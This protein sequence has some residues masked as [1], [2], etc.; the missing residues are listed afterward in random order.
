MPASKDK[1]T[2]EP[3][4]AAWRSLINVHFRVVAQIERDLAAANLISLSWY[5]VLFALV[6]APGRRL[7]LNELARKAV[8]SRS[9]LTRLVDRLDSEGLLTR[10]PCEEDRRGYHAVLTD[11]G[12][13]AVRKA[14]PVYRKGILGYFAAHL[15]ENQLETLRLIADR[16]PDPQ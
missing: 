4:V 15:T 12:L 11:R 14:W 5:D 2:E 7:R 9:G 6:T 10:E 1:K 13:E 8:L 16:V 3:G